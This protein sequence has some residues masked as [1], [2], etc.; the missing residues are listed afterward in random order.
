MKYIRSVMKNNRFTVS[1]KLRFEGTEESE[2]DAILDTGCQHSHLSIDTIFIFLSDNDLKEEKAKYMKIRN[3]GIGIGVESSNQKVNTDINDVNNPRIV[4]LQKMYD[5]KV[6]DISIGN[7]Y[8]NVSYDTSEVALIGMSLLKDWDI[9][10]GKNK[11]GE[12]VFLG[13]PYNMLN[14]EYYL[15]LENEFGIQQNIDAAIINNNF[16][17]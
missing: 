17:N 1:L 3:K 13:C 4:V 12:T 5:V 10:I 2:I 6:N 8:M 7:K 11:K 9:H 14:Q 16:N 15:A